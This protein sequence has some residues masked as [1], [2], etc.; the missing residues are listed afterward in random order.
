MKTSLDDLIKSGS[1]V[2]GWL[3]KRL[4]EACWTDINTAT[5]RAEHLL[6]EMAKDHPHRE[7]AVRLVSV[8]RERLR[9]R[10]GV[11]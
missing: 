3:R 10:G 1:G 7:D 9:V 6:A 2:S 5:A 8:L 4:T 11:E